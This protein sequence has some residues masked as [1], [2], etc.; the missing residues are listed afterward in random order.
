MNHTI[1]ANHRDIQ[2]LG[3]IKSYIKQFGYPPSILEM[4]NAFDIAQSAVGARLARLQALGWIKR[5]PRKV[6]AITVLKE[7]AA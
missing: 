3:F 4:A 2:T 1:A 6:R 7:G 5:Q